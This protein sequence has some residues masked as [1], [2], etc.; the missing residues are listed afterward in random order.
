M[1]ADSAA[2]CQAFR[3]QAQH[4]WLGDH[5]LQ[6]CVPIQSCSKVLA[7]LVTAEAPGQ[8]AVQLA[9]LQILSLSCSQLADS[10]A[11]HILPLAIRM[12]QQAQ[13]KPHWA[14]ILLC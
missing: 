3:L 12:L 4:L 7:E 11:L 5:K 10:H 6:S 1:A 2:V 13:C 8:H 9:L 14:S